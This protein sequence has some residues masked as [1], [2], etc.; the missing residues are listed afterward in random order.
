MMR[1]LAGVPLRFCPRQHLPSDPGHGDSPRH[2]STRVRL[3]GSLHV[4]MLRVSGAKIE[5][6]GAA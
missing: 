1:N 5:R 6:G 4:G 3:E 2:A